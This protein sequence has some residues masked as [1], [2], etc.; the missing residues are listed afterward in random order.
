MGYYHGSGADLARLELVCEVER[1]FGV[2]FSDESGVVGGWVTVA[3]VAG[4]VLAHRPAKPLATVT[5]AVRAL[6]ASGFGVPFE[7]VTEDAEL[8]GEPLRLGERGQMRCADP[9]AGG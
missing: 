9:P 4:S 8:F 5:A 3:D 6:I 7:L 1:R 2:A